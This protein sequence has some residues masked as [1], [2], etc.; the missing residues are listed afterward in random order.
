MQIWT[1]TVT[2][3]ADDLTWELCYLYGF[4]PSFGALDDTQFRVGTNDYTVDGANVDADVT[5]TAG[6]LA[7]RLTGALATADIVGL[8]LHVCDAA[9]ALADATVNSTQHTYNWASA[10]LDWSSDTSRTLYLSVPSDTTSTDAMLSALALSGV[11]LAPTFVSSTT[12]T[13]TVARHHATV[14]ATPTHSGATVAF[15]DG[16]D[17]ALTNPVV[18]VGATVIT[19]VT[20]RTQ[21]P[22]YG[23]GDA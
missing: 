15:K 14:T 13:A 8:T 11:T 19:V 22:S 10:G 5:T 17:T 21:P 16:D 9:F 4:G 20:A 6:R 2:V 1:G 23:D 7:F 18:A 12:Y 3:G